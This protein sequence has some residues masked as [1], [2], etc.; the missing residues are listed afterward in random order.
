MLLVRLCDNEIDW[1][2]E[3]FFRG[4]GTAENAFVGKRA[5]LTITPRREPDGTA[6]CG[7]TGTGS[8]RITAAGEVY[9][10]ERTRLHGAH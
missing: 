10:F 3:R 9:T 1:D 5:F 8:E 6:L 4:A 2:G 7:R